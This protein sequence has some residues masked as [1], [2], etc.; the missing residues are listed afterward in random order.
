[1]CR[2][3]DP[4]FRNEL[5]SISARNELAADGKDGADIRTQCRWVWRWEGGVESGKK[6]LKDAAGTS[7]IIVH[8]QSITDRIKSHVRK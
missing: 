1:M 8:T 7:E 5:L 3:Y 4:K 6:A 2:T